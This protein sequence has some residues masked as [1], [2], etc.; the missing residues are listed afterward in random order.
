[1][2]LDIDRYAHVA[3]P[4]QRW[5]TRYKVASLLIA[6]LCFAV[7][8]TLGAALLAWIA[9]TLLMRSAQIPL[10]FLWQGLRWVVLFLLPFF[11][12]L[13]LSYPGP[14][15]FAWEGFRLACLVVIKALAIVTAS[16]AIFTT[17]RF[18]VTV[19][20][21]QHLKLPRVFVQMLLFTYRYI[22]VF[23]EELRRRDTAM[24]ARGFT[25]KTNMATLQ[26]LGNFVGTILVRSFERTERIYKAMLSKG[27]VGEYPTLT[28]FSANTVDWSKAAMVI[29]VAA[30][31]VLLDQSGIFHTA[32][33]AW[34]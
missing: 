30:A 33:Q 9:A 18:D 6:I 3:S 27:Y 7:L 8:D 10:P 20:A 21:L 23:V 11:V 22:F 28:R 29:G 12:I 16:M 4:V 1:M 17:S 2:A 13:P 26:V 34:L 25:P 19:L 15:V 32:E 24:K 5:D 31:I 14:S